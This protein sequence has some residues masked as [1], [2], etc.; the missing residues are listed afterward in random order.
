MIA[1]TPNTAPT[2]NAGDDQTVT[3]GATVSLNGTLSSDPE[4][5]NSL[6]YS[7]AHTSGPTV[8]L[9]GA[10]TATPSF[11]A[12]NVGTTQNIVLT[13]TVTDSGSRTD[14]DTVTITVNDVANR[15]RPPPMPAA[16]RTSPREI[17]SR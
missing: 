14:A 5:G 12:P 11:T 9:T 10:A 3:E 13:L 1:D 2:A 17:R 4:D 7:W 16:P 8:T 6:T 15:A